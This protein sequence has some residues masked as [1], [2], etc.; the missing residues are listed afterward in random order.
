VRE[1]IPVSLAQEESTFFLEESIPPLVTVMPP[2]SMLPAARR[3]DDTHGTPEIEFET[4]PKAKGLG[5]AKK[6]KGAKIS[7]G[8]SVKAQTEGAVEVP[9][10]NASKG[11]APQCPLAEI[12]NGGVKASEAKGSKANVPDSK[13]RT[14]AVPEVKDS[15]PKRPLPK[16]KK[17]EVEASEAKPSSAKKLKTD[18]TTNSN[19]SK[20][21]TEGFAEVP[22]AE[23]PANVASE[24]P[25]TEAKKDKDPGDS[26]AAEAAAEDVASEPE[27]SV[28]SGAKGPEASRTGDSKDLREEIPTVRKR[29]SAAAAAPSVAKKAKVSEQGAADPADPAGDKGKA[30]KSLTEKPK[31]GRTRKIGQ[32]QPPAQ[33]QE[34]VQGPEE[35]AARKAAQIDLHLK[36]PNIKAMKKRLLARGMLT[37]EVQAMCL[38]ICQELCEHRLTPEECICQAR[39][40]QWN[41]DEVAKTEWTLGDLSDVTQL[42]QVGRA[43]AAHGTGL[44]K[45]KPQDGEEP[46]AARLQI[47]HD[48]ILRSRNE[49]K[50]IL[51]D[52]LGLKKHPLKFLN[53]PDNIRH[54]GATGFKNFIASFEAMVIEI[55][56]SCKQYHTDGHGDRVLGLVSDVVKQEEEAFDSGFRG[57]CQLSHSLSNAVALDLTVDEWFRLLKKKIG[58]QAGTSFF[59]DPALSLPAKVLEKLK[60]IAAASPPAQDAPAPAVTP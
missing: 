30:S 34:P 14:V 1:T 17:G 52:L 28:A 12:K 55:A 49:V 42:Q 54:F 19:P 35:R 2:S 40:V 45:G 10:V 18:R 23:A 33:A 57:L 58:D 24:I 11:S 59:L 46:D 21:Q 4:D 41:L 53:C 25:P 47:Q 6:V 51:S 9:E 26:V 7:N 32:T 48:L 20:D 22:E 16:I 37:E 36:D 31:G 3:D 15:A 29:L 56:V 39:L 60:A 27:D 8:N 13:E 44:R 38:E 5:S 50:P 43:I